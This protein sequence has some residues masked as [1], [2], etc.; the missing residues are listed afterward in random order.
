MSEETTPADA[1]APVEGSG[2]EA[3]GVETDA[4]AGGGDAP[5]AGDDARVGG[6]AVA[7]EAGEAE[8][9]PAVT[10]AEFLI[11]NRKF[12]DQKHA[13]E[14]LGSE[15]GAKRG[16]QR[17]NAELSKRLER[18]ESQIE[19]YSTRLRG[20]GSGKPVQGQGQGSNGEAESFAEHLAK[21]GQLDF[22]NKL[23]QNP[24]I[25]VA[26]A[27]FE[28]LKAQEEWQGKH[29][30]NRVSQLEERIVQSDVQRAQEAA[31]ART[32]TAAKG[33]TK[34]FPELD[35]ADPSA[36]D[37]AHEEREWIHQ[38][39]IGYLQS[40][41]QAIH[42]KTGQPVP[43]GVMWLQEKPD[44]AIRW[45][46]T[47]FRSEYGTPVFAQPPGTS[48]SPSAK[49]VAAAEKKAAAEASEP[50]DGSGVPRQR[51]G[52]QKPRT[53]ADKWREGSSNLKGREATTPSGR[54]L[55]FPAP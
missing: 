14:V 31:L 6:E 7:G 35:D 29:Q 34:E 46:A 27:I 16:L 21:S 30:D 4:S 17:Q 49:A 28:A 10:P 25:G 44:E 36:P 53:L 26:G 9:A 1:P 19:D 51:R 11:L 50:L 12:R 3:V 22:F 37:A 20:D 8:T 41:P 48:E 13:E 39:I 32:F 24:E 55:G 52:E 2:S 45:A 47:K 40:T 38:T 33:L 5:A 43:T 18:M 42:P 15:I 23:A 54:K